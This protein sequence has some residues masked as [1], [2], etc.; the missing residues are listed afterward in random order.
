MKPQFV[1]RIKMLCRDFTFMIVPNS[2]AKKIRSC[3]IPFIVMLVMLS[4]IIFN[5]Y[6]FFGFTI[7]VWH[8]SRLR[9]EITAQTAMNGRL[10]AEMSRVKPVLAKSRSIEAELNHYRQEYQDVFDAWTRVRQKG[11]LHFTL[12]SR[13][14]FRMSLKTNTYSLTPISKTKTVTTSLDQLDANLN[15]LHNILQNENRDQNRLLQTLQAYERYLDHT[16]TLWPV[17]A[18]ITSPF[19]ERFH[20]ILR[21]YI[22]HEGVDLGAEYGT[23]VRATAAGTVIFAGWEEGYGNVVKIDHEYGYE[24]RYA[25]NSQLLV[26]RGQFVKKG[27]IISLSGSTGESTA[28]HLHYEVRINGRP[29]NPV[30]FLKE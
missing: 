5:I 21:R 17:Y 23:R 20:P 14:G 29:V 26:Y 16:P 7:Q 25:H 15:Q 27:Q 28:P 13:G 19:G 1:K 10:Q 30:P 3:R 9:G 12:A 18:P 6:I 8:I 11:K 22:I 4:F 2:G 24:T